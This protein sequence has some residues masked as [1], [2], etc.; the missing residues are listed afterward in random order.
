MNEK[1]Q[2][3]QKKKKIKKKKSK[4]KKGNP[5]RGSRA[6]PA[7]LA[8]LPRA[9]PVREH[10]ALLLRIVQRKEHP[11]R[12]RRQVEPLRLVAGEQPHFWDCF[13]L[14]VCF[15]HHEGCLNMYQ[16]LILS[17]GNFALGVLSLLFFKNKLFINTRL[18]DSPL[19]VAGCVDP[20]RVSPEALTVVSGCNRSRHHA[21][22]V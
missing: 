10:L 7:G 19:I 20:P 6:D 9:D 4:K 21:T 8:A 3:N 15:F 18:L 2:K 5:P 16:F 12:H 11:R 1:T 14:C 17:F 22:T 13:F